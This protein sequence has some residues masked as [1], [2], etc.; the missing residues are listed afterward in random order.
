MSGRI[1]LRPQRAINIGRVLLALTYLLISWSFRD[2]DVDQAEWVELYT[3]AL[4]LTLA[5]IGAI[6]ALRSWL[7]EAAMR[8]PL[9]VLDAI[10]YVVLITHTGGGGSPYKAAFLLL[11]MVAVLNLPKVPKSIIP[12]SAVVGYLI[13]IAFG[14]NASAG[15]ENRYEGVALNAMHMLLLGTFVAVFLSGGWRRKV[16]A[17]ARNRLET[18]DLYE[19]GYSLLELA[20]AGSKKAVGAQQVH[21]LIDDMGELSAYVA[22]AGQPTVRLEA[23]SS[24]I[25]SAMTLPPHSSLI[26]TNGLLRCRL[27]QP[28]HRAYGPQLHQISHAVGSSLQQFCRGDAVLLPVR[29]LDNVAYL[30]LE[31]DEPLTEAHML[32]A[33]QSRQR[34][35]QMV[36]NYERRLSV[37]AIARERERHKIWRN[38]HDGTVQ[39]LSA[40]HLHLSRLVA[41]PDTDIATRKTLDLVESI[42]SSEGCRLREMSDQP[43]LAVDCAKLLQRTADNLER[44]WQIDCSFT[45]C[46]N[47]KKVLENM[48]DE[49]AAIA[50]DFAYAME[51]MVA[52]GVRHGNASK[53]IFKLSATDDELK[54]SLHGNGRPPKSSQTLPKSLSSRVADMVGRLTFESE[55]DGFGMQ[56]VV[57][58]RGNAN[59]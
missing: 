54:L 3:L 46:D 37:L 20:V 8:F 39:S 57:K 10:A 42:V 14:F 13:A 15:P 18:S 59:G 25:A 31:F 28:P 29:I 33:A 52:N 12:I 45:Q 34:I 21:L 55:Q 1:V 2:F 44:K 6:F 47:V 19:A 30:L 26:R 56:I 11:V 32:R 58:N 43:V 50:H 22:Q 36:E 7:A 40:I 41:S 53:I 4:Y 27:S 9:L 23:D 16:Q 38:L 51:E 48:P 24:A 35:T 49:G 5:L 17:D